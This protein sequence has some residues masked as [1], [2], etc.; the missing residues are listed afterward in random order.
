MVQELLNNKADIDLPSNEGGTP[1]FVACQCNHLNVVK[2]LVQR[3][4][5][6][7]AKMKVSIIYG[8]VICLIVN[9]RC[10]IEKTFLPICYRVPTLPQNSSILLIFHF[11]LQNSSYLIKKTLN[12]VDFYLNSSKIFNSNTFILVYFLLRIDFVPCSTI[13]DFY[14][15]IFKIMAVI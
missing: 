15:L 7:H 3:G 6:I 10:L 2:E 4:A 12:F 8:V 1:L 14:V 5:N 9:V 13:N 11:S